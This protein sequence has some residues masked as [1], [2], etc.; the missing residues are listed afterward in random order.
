MFD[1]LVGPNQVTFLVLDIVFHDLI[2]RFCGRLTQIGPIVEQVV[3]NLGYCFCHE[4]LQGGLNDFRLFITK[5][6]SEVAIH[7]LYY[8]ILL[9][10]VG[11]NGS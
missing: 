1:V 9:I 10:G 11:V 4:N 2:V 6:F 8:R 3:V 5:Q 7:L